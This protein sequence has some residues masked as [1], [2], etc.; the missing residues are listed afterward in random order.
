MV[1]SQASQPSLAEIASHV[2]MSEFHFQRLFS[3][4]AGISPKKFLM[5]LTVESLKREVKREGSLSEI[6]QR[7][8]LSAPSRVHDHFVR[9]ECI[10]PGTY[11]NGGD[12]LVIGYGFGDSVFGD[13]F[14]AGTEQGIMGLGF[15]DGNRGAT[16]SDFMHRWPNARFIEDPIYALHQIETINRL[17]RPVEEGDHLPRFNVLVKGTSFQIKVWEA[18]LKIPQ[19]C[20]LSYSKLANE[21][22]HPGADRAVGSAVGRNPVSWLIPCHRVIRQQGVLGNYHWDPLRKAAMIGLER[23][24]DVH[25]IQESNQPEISSK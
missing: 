22:G 2:H 15:S 20:L 5:Y 23:S 10:T 17:L 9:I 8:G 12:G 6:A 4:W 1:R 19:G 14:V 24:L 3:E 16:L 21:I 18:L 13:C 25:Y 11:R 7:V